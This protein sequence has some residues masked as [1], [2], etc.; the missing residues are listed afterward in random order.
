MK[1][2][3]KALTHCNQFIDANRLDNIIV[4]I[5]A[6]RLKVDTKEICRKEGIAYTVLDIVTTRDLKDIDRAEEEYR[7]RYMC[8]CDRCGEPFYSTEKYFKTCPSCYI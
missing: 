1:T 2:K 7:E 4:A 3:F 8:I 6:D 5:I